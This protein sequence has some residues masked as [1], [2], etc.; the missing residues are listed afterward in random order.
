M[1]DNNDEEDNVNSFYRQS[2]RREIE[3][4]VGRSLHQRTE[5]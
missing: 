3:Y 4:V 1:K 2:A 5:D